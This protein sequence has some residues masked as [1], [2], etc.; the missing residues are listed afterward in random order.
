MPSESF[1]AFWM[2]V[3]CAVGA[4]AGGAWWA[5]SIS[6]GIN[7]LKELVKNLVASQ[8]NTDEKI[9]ALEKRVQLLEFRAN[10]GENP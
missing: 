1:S 3:I 4:I 2:L 7:D 5:S 8:D 6:A 9:R 10:K